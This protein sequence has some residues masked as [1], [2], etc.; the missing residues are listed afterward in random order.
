MT[1]IEPLHVSDTPLSELPDNVGVQARVIADSIGPSGQRVTTIEATMHRFVLA[2]FNTH[3]VFSRNSASSRAIPVTKQLDKVERFPAFP[4]EWPCEKPGMQGGVEL[5][6]EDLRHA[7]RLFDA[8]HEHVC[9]EIESYL[10]GVELRHP[11]LDTKELKA[12]T[13]H[14]SLINRLL[15]PFMWHTVAATSTEWSGFFDQRCSPLAQPEIRVAAEAIRDVYSASTPEP[16][17]YGEWHLPYIRPEDLVWAAGNFGEDAAV[18]SLKQISAARCARTSYL[19]HNGIRDPFDDIRLFNDLV[20]ADPM[21]ASPLEHPCTPARPEDIQFGNLFG[22]HQLRQEIEAAKLTDTID[23]Q[24]SG[25]KVS[26]GRSD[27]TGV[28][29]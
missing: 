12:H 13:L 7:R 17:A 19:T 6:G 5:E 8:I 4:L 2:E 25:P 28:A 9:I 3:R 21:H 27:E 29:A 26:V 23:T 10:T 18:D 1:T 20:S 16:L 11:E 24:A 14:K 22:F 15:E